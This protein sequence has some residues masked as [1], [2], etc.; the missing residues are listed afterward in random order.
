MSFIIQFGHVVSTLG[1]QLLHVNMTF[2]YFLHLLTLSHLVLLLFVGQISGLVLGT[3]PV[4]RID[5]CNSTGLYF[6]FALRILMPY[7]AQS[8]MALS[9]ILRTTIVF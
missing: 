7:Q 3:A 8:V 1:N 9:D 2:I 4:V 5:K 6:V